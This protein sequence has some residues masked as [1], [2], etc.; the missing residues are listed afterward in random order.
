M[1]KTVILSVVILCA[2]ALYAYSQATSA[3]DIFVKTVPITKIYTHQ[4]GYKVLYLKSNLQVGVIYI[5]LSWVGHSAGGKAVLVWESSWVS[6]YFSIFWV[7]G[8]FDHI[9]LHVPSNLQ[10]AT[11]G[12][13]ETTLDMDAAFNVQEPKMEF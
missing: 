7:D 13:L 12:V 1:K 6:P 11:W 3:T 10:S 5:P 9:V 2:A 4:L 8:K